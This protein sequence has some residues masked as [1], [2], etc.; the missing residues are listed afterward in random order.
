ME[1]KSV[2]GVITD[3]KELVR[4]RGAAQRS[5]LSGRRSPTALQ[6]GAH[7]SAFRGRGLE[8]DEVRIYQSGDD[9][10]SID[11]RV[12]ARR[13]KPHTKLFREERERP[14]L[15]LVDLTPGMF[16]G[17]RLQ[18]KSVLAA[19]ASALFAWSAVSCGDRV[20]GAVSGG[21]GVRTVLPRPRQA[22]VLGL[23]RAVVELQPVEPGDIEHDRLDRT[24]AAIEKMSRTG[25]LV[26]I[27]SDFRELGKRGSTLLRAIA[28][29]ND[30]IACL[31]HDALESMPP[32]PGVYRFGSKNSRVTVDTSLA[33][34]QKAWSQQFLRHREQLHAVT[35]G[36]AVK[37]LDFPSDIPAQ[38]LVRRALSP[39]GRAV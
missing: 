36:L 35:R 4:L 28:M 37:W 26:V 2:P 15:L 34:V 8:F 19:R 9:V 31:I 21:I 27:L 33:Q 10:R 20:G 24:L 14:V 29:R 12:T 17:T 5:V 18:F 30:V 22:G 38:R 6:A 11:W 25:S 32:P 23:L 1:I 39:V 16:F 3:L 7:R 13:G